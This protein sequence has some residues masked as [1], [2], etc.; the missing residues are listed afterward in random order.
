MQRHQNAERALPVGHVV[1]AV[2][3]RFGELRRFRFVSGGNQP[4]RNAAQPANAL[5]TRRQ[6]VAL[7]A[8]EPVRGEQV[9][10]QSGPDR[11]PQS[12]AGGVDRV[13]IDDLHP[14]GNQRIA[15]KQY[16]F[17][18]ERRIKGVRAQRRGNRAD[19]RL[20]ID[21]V[22]AGACGQRRHHQVLDRLVTSERIGIALREAL[23]LARPDGPRE[24]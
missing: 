7:D 24:R 10:L 17:R 19:H 13:R 3:L 18:L 2:K 11:L 23:E 21:L 16:G 5:R 6:I 1:G 12:F 4:E 15:G 8:A 14:F 22:P 9:I 20:G